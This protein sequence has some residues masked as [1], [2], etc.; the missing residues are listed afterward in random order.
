MALVSLTLQYYKHIVMIVEKFI[1]K[2]LSI[3]YI[4]TIIIFIMP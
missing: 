3:L 1:S 4:I 2:V